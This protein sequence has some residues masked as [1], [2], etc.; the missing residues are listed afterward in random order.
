MESERYLLTVFLD[1]QLVL[2]ELQGTIHNTDGNRLNGMELGKLEFVNVF[3]V[4]D[5]FM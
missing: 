5:K 1:L 2:L 3:V 4:V